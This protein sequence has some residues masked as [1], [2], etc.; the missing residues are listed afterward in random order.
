M[1][2]EKVVLFLRAR[3]PLGDSAPAGSNRSGHGGN[4]VAEAF[5]VEG[6][7]VKAS[8]L[9]YPGRTVKGE[10]LNKARKAGACSLGD[11]VVSHEDLIA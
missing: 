2:H 8:E 10:L 9:G 7:L 3:I 1:R 11:W 4:E 6:H 5:D